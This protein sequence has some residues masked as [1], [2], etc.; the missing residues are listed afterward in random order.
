[1]VMENRSEFVN[2]IS[3]MSRHNLHTIDKDENIK[4]M[5]GSY[6]DLT[7]IICFPTVEQPM[8]L[9]KTIKK[10]MYQYNYTK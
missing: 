6:G 7:F 4:L 2:W 3:H 10:D 5:L 8:S 9:W 1:M